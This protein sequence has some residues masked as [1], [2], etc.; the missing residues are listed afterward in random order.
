[1]VARAALNAGLTYSQSHVTSHLKE[2]GTEDVLN[3]VAL[4]TAEEIAKGSKAT[5]T[6]LLEAPGCEWSRSINKETSHWDIITA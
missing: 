4:V 1:M 5:I 3:N 6:R 2:E